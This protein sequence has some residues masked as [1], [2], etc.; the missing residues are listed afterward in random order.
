M[1]MTFLQNL[2]LQGTIHLKTKTKTNTCALQAAWMGLLPVSPGWAQTQAWPIK[3]FPHT[4]SSLNDK[5]M[6]SLLKVCL[7]T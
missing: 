1:G 7:G 4:K 5:E 3:V 2:C 6:D